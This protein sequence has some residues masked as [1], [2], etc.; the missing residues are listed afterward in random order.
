LKI[1]LGGLKG[2]DNDLLIFLKEKLGVEVSFS[3]ADN[4]MLLDNSSRKKP[5]KASTVKTYVKRFLHKEGLRQKYRV[6]VEKGNVKLVYH[7]EKK[8]G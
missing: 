3:Q 6:F 5:L 2:K 1:D 8:E 7:K 4:S